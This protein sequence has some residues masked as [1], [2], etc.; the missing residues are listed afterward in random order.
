MHLSIIR[1]LALSGLFFFVITPVDAAG[2]A[3]YYS[4]TYSGGDNGTWTITISSGGSI[5]GMARSGIDESIYTVNGQASSSGSLTMT[6]G[7][8][9]DGATFAGTIN[10][11]TGVISGTWTNIYYGIGGS[12]SG[13]L[14]A[15]FKQAPFVATTTTN[16]TA[17]SATI[18]TRITFNN[19]DVGKQG[20]VFITSWAPA[21]GLSAFGILTAGLNKAMS[22]TVTG[23]N[24]YLGG[25]VNSRQGIL[26]AIMAITDPAFVLIQRTPSGWALVSNGQLTP[27][28]TGV[29]GDSLASMNILNNTN[30]ANLLGSQFCVGYGTSAAEM[31]AAGRMQPVAIIP[32]TTGNAAANGSCN[33]TGI[34]VEF[35]NTNLDNYFITADA[36][37]AAQVDNGMAGRAGAAPATLSG[38][39][40][41]PLSAVS[42]AAT[43][44]ARTRISIRSIRRNARG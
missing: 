13:K 18:T 38:R 7:S 4:G 44:P 24:P 15:A 35:Y 33:V 29:L 12:F 3:G 42:T 40:A 37:E 23:D 39:A 5:T 28:T 36:G 22:V 8:V 2:Y 11:T 6:S 19:P 17:T 32:D 16:I 31:I 41:V 10:S 14:A 30:P 21:N 25:E 9:S 1:L 20:A 34:V 27:Y 26:G 43:R